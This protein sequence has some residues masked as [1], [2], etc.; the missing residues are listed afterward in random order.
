MSNWDQSKFDEVLAGYLKVTS[1]TV[2]QALNNKAYFVA[3]KAL[4]VTHKA[5][6][7][8][9]RS[10]LTTV[11]ITTTETGYTYESTLAERIIWARAKREGLKLN[12]DQV[13]T[14]AKALVG[15]RLRSVAFIKSGWIPSIRKLEGLVKDRKGAAGSDR[16]ARQYG[17]DKGQCI[18]AVEGGN[19]PVAT[20]INS[21]KA[22]GDDDSALE[23][24][25]GKG[26]DLAFYDETQSMIEYI[27][28]KMKPDADAANLK[29]K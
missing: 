27:E 22:K 24:H 23:K 16:E 11:S 6:A 26:L 1:R 17:A 5:D 14:A 13:A 19:N 9:I 29:L 7:N 4:W 12:R 2:P 21:A 10:E 3:R 18:P 25:G 20:I 8:K 15:A 28:S